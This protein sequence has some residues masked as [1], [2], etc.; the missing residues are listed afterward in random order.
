MD[1][2]C[3]QRKILI[4]QILISAMKNNFIIALINICSKLLSPARTTP[5]S[6]LV[7]NNLNAYYEAQ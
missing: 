6:K 1:I 7:K 5:R 3:Y 2:I 4:Y